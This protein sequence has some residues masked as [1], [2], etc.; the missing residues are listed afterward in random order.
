MDRAIFTALS[1]AQHILDQQ[2]TNM[3]NLANGS[4]TGFKGQMES[5]RSIQVS[6]TGH[7]SRTLVT[8]A[9]TSDDFSAG[10][11]TQTGRILDVAI[12]GQGWFSVMRPDGSEAYTRN[13][14]FQVDQ[15]GFLQTASGLSV[16]GA[17]GP[18]TI[19]PESIISIAEDGTIS[20]MSDNLIPGASNTIDRLKLSKPS[21]DNLTRTP[22]GLFVIADGAQVPVAEDVKVTSGAIEGSNVNIVSAMVNMIS[23]SRQFDVQMKIIHSIE[24]NDSKASDLYKLT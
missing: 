6:G 12:Q 14:S 10:P 5:F 1:G 15:N 17:S 24:A 21:E 13:G 19:P 11:I 16:L 8:N 9:L 18:I 22:E 23:L 2:A 3:N 7:A 20:T 4:S